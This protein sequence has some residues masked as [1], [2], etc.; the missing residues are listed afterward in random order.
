MG[1]L[2]TA[3]VLLVSLAMPI[4]VS[5]SVSAA[6]L[7]GET[8]SGVSTVANAWT[9]GGAGGSVACLTAA[10]VSAVNSIPRCSASPTDTNGNGFLRLTPT[11]LSAAGFALYNTPISAAAGLD[12]QF[13][14]YQYGGTGADGISFFLVDGA[15]SPTQPGAY[16]G[17]LGYSGNNTG[18]IGIVGGYV[19]IGF[20]RYGNFSHSDFGNG[21]PGMFPNSITVRGSEATSYQFVSRKSATAT[22][23]GTTRANSL[24]RVKINVSTANIMSVS[25]D[26]GSGYVSELSGL[27][28][29]TING[30][31]TMP[32][33]FKL[34]FAASTGGSTN[35]HEIGGLAVKTNPP[36]VSVQASNSGPFTQGGTG[37]F[38]VNA[39]NDASAEATSDT[40]TTTNTL[41]A[42]LTPTSASGTGWNCNI[43]GQVVTCSRPGDGGNALSPGQTTPN[44]TINIAVAANATT[45]LGLSSVL[46][47]SGNDP[48]ATVTKT[49][50][51]V[52]QTGSYLDDDGIFNAVEATAP[53]GGDG[54]DDGIA[55]SQQDNVTSLPNAV[56][57]KYS[58]LATTGCLGTNGGVS[59]GAES[60]NSV[61]DGEYTYPAGMMNFTITCSAPGGTSTVTQYFYG[62]YDAAKVVAR[63][64][65]STNGTYQTISGATLSNVTI[66]GEAALKIEYQIT[67]G[68]VLDQ[69]GLANGIIVDPAGPALLT[70][71]L[72][73]SGTPDTGLAAQPMYVYY[74]AGLVGIGLIIY[75]ITPRRKKAQATSK[76]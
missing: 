5:G 31:G 43:V 58:V 26:Y 53:N 20:D 71:S 25:V 46:D 73:A 3:M 8:F 23:S 55:D 11:A 69:D 39:K 49:S 45:P 10:S 57:G 41:A 76:S 68:G 34:G 72:V 30:A 62:A 66:G 24:R 19:G 54:N 14:M 60:A 1:R 67:D 70:T 37:T 35:T 75:E 32:A 42:G 13:S 50:N 18:G 59:L 22:L 47:I 27:N 21:G 44:I 17:S 51:A 64:Y 2:L 28:L 61:G 74:T 7:A 29:A 6:A 16:G 38:T 52:V 12:I 33:N 36:N 56:S 63:K 40:I 48:L 4:F 15:A 65:N 9:S